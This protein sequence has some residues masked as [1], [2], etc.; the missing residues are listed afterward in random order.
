MLIIRIA[1]LLTARGVFGL[2]ERTQALECG[3]DTES[4]SA[5]VLLQHRHKSIIGNA[6]VAIDAS[7]G[8]N[9]S[10]AAIANASSELI[11][12][13]SVF[14]IT[15]PIKAAY[16]FA[17]CL[18]LGIV[19]LGLLW[20]DSGFLQ[21]FGGGFSFSEKDAKAFA[22][23]CTYLVMLVSMDLVIK[24]EAERGNG[25]YATSPLV[26]VPLAEFGKLVA[27]VILYFM[28]LCLNDGH[29]HSSSPPAAL[30]VMRESLAE[31]TV[32]APR[33]VLKIAMLMLPVALIYN[34]NNLLVFA[35]LATIK[36]DAYAVWRNSSILFNAIL[37]VW[38]FGKRLQSHRWI[39]IVI[40]MAA[41]C[42]NSLQL[43]GRLVFGLPVAGVVLSAFLSSIA[44]VFNEYVIKARA[45]TSLGLDQ[46]NM[47]LYVETLSL[48]LLGFAC[49]VAI[50]SSVT[51]SDIVD[52]FK[53]ITTGGMRIAM[54]QVALGL[55]V[56]RVLKFADSV[57]KT[58]VG[59]LRDVVVVAV[60]PFFVLQTRFD[61]VA[62]SSVAWMAV[63]GL[64]YFTTVVDPAV[65]PPEACSSTKS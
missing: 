55:T 59:S 23:L 20:R 1:V 50:D 28:S 9:R 31:S 12:T 65:D 41:C 54:M 32:V 29:K 3:S 14:V 57:A 48:M 30:A 39:A 47:I 44:S 5:S 8:Q 25:S 62:I 45:S 27:S 17:Y 18:P 19:Y 26:M 40:C 56:S 63:G 4:L 64:I 10:P 46:I 43:D 15:V 22:A 51:R 16:I 61:W 13:S 37:W 42:L 21:R 52:R 24:S 53:N 6:S 36:L 60:A 11:D 58:V 35:V 38:M 49:W 2:L 34:L 7:V 33:A